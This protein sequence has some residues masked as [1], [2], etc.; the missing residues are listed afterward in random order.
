MLVLSRKQGERVV[1]GIDI[2][3]TI[4]E[5]SASGV[6]LGITAPQEPPVHREEA[7]ERIARTEGSNPMS[8]YREGSPFFPEC[9]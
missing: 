2:V 9:N 7:L 4:V 5:C 1:I 6:R 3:I 8:D